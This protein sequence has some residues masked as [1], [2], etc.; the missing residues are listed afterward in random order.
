MYTRIDHQD[1]QGR[2]WQ[3]EGEIPNNGVDD[4]GN[5]FVDDVHGYDFA[6][7]DGDPSDDDGHGT[8]CAGTMGA[9][10]AAMILF[11][12]FRHYC[13]LNECP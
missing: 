2:L 12:C 10:G 7:E 4:D 13:H 5:G 11:R 3:N 8:H 9:K 6:D 1:L